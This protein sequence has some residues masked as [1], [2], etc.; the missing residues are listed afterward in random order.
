MKNKVKMFKSQAE[1]VKAVM[2]INAIA[3]RLLQSIT[4]NILLR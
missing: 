1:H 3:D 2:T 4:L